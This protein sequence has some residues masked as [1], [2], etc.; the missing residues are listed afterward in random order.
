MVTTAS[1]AL[2]PTSVQGCF[3]IQ[4]HCYA[5]CILPMTPHDLCFLRKRDAWVRSRYSS[6]FRRRL[7]PAFAI[8]CLTIELVV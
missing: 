2:H 7:M 3:V 4:W 8:T 5:S 1:H 6:A